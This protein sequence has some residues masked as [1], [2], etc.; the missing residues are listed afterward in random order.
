M[1]TWGFARSK[2][3]Q[4]AQ[5]RNKLKVCA[6][7]WHDWIEVL[8]VIAVLVLLVIGIHKLRQP[9]VLP[10]AH[11]RF[12]H[13]VKESAVLR[14]IVGAQVTGNFFTVNLRAIERALT[15]PRWIESASVRREWPD[16]LSIRVSSYEPVARWGV[17]ALLS[18]D[19]HVFRPRD[20]EASENLPVLHGP[21]G[22]TT[23]LLHA[24]RRVARTLSS[25]GLTAGALVQDQ[26]RAWHLL[27]GADIPVELGRG[28]PL[29]RV[30]RLARVYPEALAS[31]AASIKSIDL[32]Y[33]NGLA[34]AWKHVGKS[35]ADASNATSK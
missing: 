30:T 28:D 2:R 9:D 20:G 27:L 7:S 8:A 22:R 26:R 11:V 1:A 33:T 17:D 24:Y 13:G 15:R 32:R 19:G 14:K 21:A 35:G 29:A 10:I 31:R 5:P 6:L 12:E 25:A 34:V 3:R 18:G 4:G 23:Y 16:T